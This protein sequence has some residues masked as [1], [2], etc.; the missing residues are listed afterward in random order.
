MFQ[1]LL[2][3]D[4]YNKD[5]TSLGHAQRFTE[6]LIAHPEK[7]SG[8]FLVMIMSTADDFALGLQST[9]TEILRHIILGDKK[10]PADNSDILLAVD[11]LND[12]QHRLFD[13]GDDYV[14]LVTKYIEAEDAAFGKPTIS[15]RSLK[16]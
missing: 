1:E 5:I 2:G 8:G 16:E 3:H 6:F 11:S 4:N 15:A 13:A 9:Q 14:E 7:N 12:C 10:L